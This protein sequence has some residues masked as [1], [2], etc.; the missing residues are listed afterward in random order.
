MSPSLRLDAGPLDFRS[1]G[2]LHRVEPCLGYLAEFGTT[3]RHGVLSTTVPAQIEPRC[4]LL[5]D[6]KL[7][8]TRGDPRIRSLDLLLGRLTS[9]FPRLVV[10]VGVDGGDLRSKSARSSAL[11]WTAPGLSRRARWRTRRARSLAFRPR[12]QRL[13]Q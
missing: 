11:R 13:V 4:K 12:H 6:A 3:G 9:G 10:I 1:R 2:L 5:R 8:A 7:L